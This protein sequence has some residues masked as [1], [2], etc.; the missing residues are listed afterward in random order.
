MSIAD[1]RAASTHLIVSQAAFEHCVFVK[2][3]LSLSISF[4]RHLKQ[5][6]DNDAIRT[7][8]KRGILFALKLK[9]VFR[10]L[11]RTAIN[12]MPNAD[13]MQLSKTL[14]YSLVSAMHLNMPI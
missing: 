7:P 6:L 4:G 2:S 10:R 1:K 13:I 14:Q 12:G 8:Q 9:R 5:T 3:H 11:W